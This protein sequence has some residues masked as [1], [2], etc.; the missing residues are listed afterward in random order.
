MNIEDIK[1]EKSKQSAFLIGA[2][3]AHNFNGFPE[4]SVLSDKEN[5]GFTPDTKFQAASLSKLVGVIV[6]ALYLKTQKLSLDMPV[7]NF[8]AIQTDKRTTFKHL[9]SHCAGINVPGFPG[10]KAQP[11]PTMPEI[12][13]GKYPA[14][15]GEIRYNLPFGE[16]SY[17]GGG[18]CLA[19]NI[20]EEM[21]G[22]NFADLAED[23]LFKPL[24][25]HNTSFRI[26]TEDK[27]CA[28]GHD[29]NGNIIG[30]GWHLYPETIAAGL[31]TT[32]LDYL[33]ILN[34]LLNGFNALSSLIPEKIAQDILTPSVRYEENGHCYQ[35]APGIKLYD[36][37]IYGHS[38]NNRGYKCLFAFSLKERKAF[39]IMSN[40]D[41]G[42]DIL[43]LCS[44]LF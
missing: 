43:D 9:F 14:N 20:I 29:Q 6:T 2:V 40:D 17:S 19:Q 36:K 1:K 41:N 44:G 30:N 28:V 22:K 26:V 12:I 39:V 31:W 5:R 7:A 4:F 37:D 10:Y 27:H 25:L 21:S 42:E 15:T 23:F 33:Q 34:E 35:H 3:L 32:P 24:K 38:G 13:F 11:L 8:S 18:Y 16:F